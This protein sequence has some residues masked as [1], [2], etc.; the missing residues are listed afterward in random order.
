MNYLS[1]LALILLCAACFFGSVGMSSAIAADPQAEDGISDLVDQMMPY[2]TPTTCTPANQEQM[3]KILDAAQKRGVSIYKMW[4]I[5]LDRNEKLLNEGKPH[6]WYH[7]GGNS[8]W[9]CI[10]VHYPDPNNRNRC[11]A[12]C[13]ARLKFK[14]SDDGKSVQSDGSEPYS[15]EF[16]EKK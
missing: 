2:M 15:K 11:I 9:T 1:K 12:G 10:A 3:R 13:K 8:S 5:V 7:S 14:L 16:L 6:F 4:F